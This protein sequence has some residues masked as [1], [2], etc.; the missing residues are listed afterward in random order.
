MNVQFCSVVAEKKA[1]WPNLALDRGL[2]CLSRHVLIMANFVFR[3]PATGLNDQD[4]L[5]DDP[6]ISE[7]EYEGIICAACG[8]LALADA[9]G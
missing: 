9:P 4:Q 7:N 6:D 1:A 5:D 2:G 8:V 3:C